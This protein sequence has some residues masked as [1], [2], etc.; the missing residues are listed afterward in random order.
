MAEI[1]AEAM[2][3]AQEHVI[4]GEGK[5]NLTTI[6]NLSGLIREKMETREELI[7]SFVRLLDDDANENRTDRLFE[8]DT[9][10]SDL[11]RDIRIMSDALNR[12]IRIT[13]NLDDVIF[14]SYWR[15][16]I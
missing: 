8:I 16:E 3:Q 9:Q 12:M 4:G 15:A 11:N 10:V 7:T 1:T 13:I 5:M 6:K 14:D 2:R